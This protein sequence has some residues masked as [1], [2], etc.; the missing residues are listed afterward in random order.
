VRVYPEGLGEWRRLTTF[1]YPNTLFDD[2]GSD[3]AVRR[4]HAVPFWETNAR[5]GRGFTGYPGLT[6]TREAAAW[7]EAVDYLYRSGVEPVLVFV[8]IAVYL[9]VVGPGL[10]LVLRRLGRLIWL[11][12]LQPVVVIVFLV[13]TIMIGYITFG[14]LSTSWQTVLVYQDEN[15][16][17]GA[18]LALLTR[19]NPG[20]G[21]GGVETGDGSLPCF[22]V[23]EAGGFRNQTWRIDDRGRRLEEIVFPQWSWSH[24]V[25]RGPVELRGALRIRETYEAPRENEPAQPLEVYEVTNEYPFPVTDFTLWRSKGLL[26][27]RGEIAPGETRSFRASETLGGGAWEDPRWRRVIE[28]ALGVAGSTK[29]SPAYLV[30]FDPATLP[31]GVPFGMT[32]ELEE[33][34][35]ILIAL[36]KR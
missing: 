19:Y 27:F 7:Y 29:R 24:F 33:N 4:V 32:G 11:L 6:P 8:I 28:N 15:S 26:R 3:P 10:F 5:M 21:S 30:E 12:W 2:D 16:D 17:W 1:G 9:L 31:G 18:G 20:A 23:R 13:A 25:S 14:V 35:G 36:E 22:L 34:R